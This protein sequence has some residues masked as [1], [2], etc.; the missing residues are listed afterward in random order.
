M[1]ISDKATQ[2]EELAREEALRQLSLPEN[3][4]GEF[5]QK[6]ASSRL[7]C[8]DCGGRIPKRRRLAVPG[9]TRCVGCQA[10][11]EIGYP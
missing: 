1:D 3:E 4:H 9:C 5:R 2:Q 7:F 8:E 6:S 10:Y 11:Q